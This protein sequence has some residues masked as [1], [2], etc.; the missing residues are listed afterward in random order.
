MQRKVF[1]MYSPISP[2]HDLGMKIDRKS[3]F[4]LF[5]WKLIPSWFNKRILAKS[6]QI[7]LYRRLHSIFIG[8]LNMHLATWIAIKAL[9]FVNDCK[10]SYVKYRRW[11]KTLTS[12]AYVLLATYL[13]YLYCNSEMI[14]YVSYLEVITFALH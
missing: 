14:G 4:I 1:D 8:Q 6:I 5:L 7:N 13:T 11:K 2:F 9:H 12:L 10:S 3:P